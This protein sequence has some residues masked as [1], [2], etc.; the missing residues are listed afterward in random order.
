MLIPSSSPNLDIFNPRHVA[1]SN[2]TATTTSP[3]SQFQV[4]L[5]INTAIAVICFTL[6][7]FLRT[8]LPKIFLPRLVHL[9][10]SGYVLCLC[11][12][13]CQSR[14]GCVVDVPHR[15]WRW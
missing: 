2:A 8:C 5:V 11:V 10:E 3:D 12:C 4:A 1:M 9:D 7:L 6:F 13:V 15:H 14:G